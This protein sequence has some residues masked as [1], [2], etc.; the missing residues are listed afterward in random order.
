MLYTLP[1][2]IPGR[3]SNSIGGSGADEDT[4]G[5]DVL[6]GGFGFRLATDQQNP[7]SRASEP[8]TDRRFDSSLEPGEQTLAQL[9]W[10]KAQSSFHAGAGQKNLEQGFTAFQYQQEQVEHIR[11]EISQGVNVWT[12]GEVTRLNSTAITSFTGTITQLVGGTVSGVDYAVGGGTNTL[13]QFAFSS[14][15]DAAPIVTDIDLTGTDFGGKSNVTVSSLVSDGAHYF[16]LLQLTLAGSVGA[17]IHTLVVKGSLSSTAAPTVLY[18]SPADSATHPGALGWAKARLVAGLDQS[19]YTLDVGASAVDWTTLTANYAYPSDSWTWTCFADSPDAILGAG[20]VDYQSSILEFTLDSSGGA[21]TLTGGNTAA[22]LPPGEVLYSMQ[23]MLGVF[24]AIGSSQGIRIGTYDTYNGKL[25]LGPISVTTTSPVYALSGRD[26]FVFGSYNNQQ[27]DGKTG[28]FAL[29][30]SFIVDAGGRM[31]YAPDLR[32]PTTATTGLGDVTA[33]ALLPKDNRLMFVSD[34]GLHVE[35]STTDTQ[36]DAYLRTSRIRFDTTENKLFKFGR[37]TGTL[38]TNS[39][40]VYGLTPYGQKYNL[41]TIGNLASGDPGQ[42]SLPSG[43]HEW[44]QLEFHLNGTGCTLNTYQAKAYPAPTRQHII[45]LTLNCFQNEVDRNGLD[46]SDPQT[47][48]QRY[49]NLRELENIGDEIRLVEFDNNGGAVAEM[50]LIDQ[51][52]FKS[53]SRPTVDDTFGGYITMK[54]RATGT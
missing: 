27:P 5:Y 8:S 31:A 11:Y 12:P 37:I 15:G 26:R 20:S 1:A 29:D 43:L 46:V 21:P 25:Q 16:A 3:T 47:P 44:I 53:F 22:D 34:D 48:R 2:V 18:K 49:Q 28:L 51:M 54:L 38:T 50:V 33:V 52:E 23:S 7:Y 13:I 6:I 17:N 45:L 24:L 41:G 14:G 30:L 9:P 10:I 39:I 36:D 19:L 42:F 35:Q 40:T 32:P 4:G